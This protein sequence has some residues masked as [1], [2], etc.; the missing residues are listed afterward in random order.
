M[1]SGAE[2]L[3]H[4]QLVLGGGDAGHRDTPAAGDLVTEAARRSPGSSSRATQPSSPS[5]SASRTRQAARR[6]RR[7]SSGTATTAPTTS[8]ASSHHSHVGVSSSVVSPRRPDRPPTPRT[9][10]TTARTTRW[11]S[12][13]R[14]R[15]VGVLVGLRLVGVLGG[16]ST[17]SGSGDS[18]VSG[19]GGAR[20]VRRTAN[21]SAHGSA[22]GWALRRRGPPSPLHAVSEAARRSATTAPETVFGRARGRS[23]GSL[24]RLSTLLAAAP[25]WI[26][27]TG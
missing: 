4:G 17:G 24:P 20:A 1:S 2:G 23:T 10:R 3:E 11:P 14:G 7:T 12:Q 5:A 25:S 26:T 19:I 27:L 13:T 9:A 6:R 22:R 16:F 18:A 21:G 15:L 8:A